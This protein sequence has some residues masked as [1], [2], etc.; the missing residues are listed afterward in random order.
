MDSHFLM[1]FSFPSGEYLYCFWQYSA[2]SDCRI[3]NISLSFS[4]DLP[5]DLH[6]FEHLLISDEF[7]KNNRS[8]LFLH[9]SFL[10]P[11]AKTAKSENARR[12]IGDNCEANVYSWIFP[13]SFYS[14]SFKVR[15]E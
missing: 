10:A 7:P 1:H 2:Q 3:L 5:T 11:E 15:N 6:F 9:L 12:I 14:S 4:L 8:Q 13:F